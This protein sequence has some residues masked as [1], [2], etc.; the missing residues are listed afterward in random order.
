M[1]MYGNPMSKQLPPTA[2]SVKYYTQGRRRRSHLEQYTPA[3]LY[4]V[5]THIVSGVLV[6]LTC[7]VTFVPTG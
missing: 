1:S 2:N 7:E 3:L 4:P 6:F 5:R